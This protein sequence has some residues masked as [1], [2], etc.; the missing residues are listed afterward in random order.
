MIGA[1]RM[2]VAGAAMHRRALVPDQQI[3]DLPGM[4]IDK[5]LLRGMRRQLFDQRPGG[6][7]MH[8]DKAMRVH[9][10]D[11][12][13]RAAGDRVRDDRGPGLFGVF[14]FGRALVVA[15]QALAGRSVAAAV[16][17]DE[18]GQPLLHR[19][20]QRVIGGRI[21]ANIVPPLRRR[22]F[23]RVQHREQRQFLFIGRVGVPIGGALD[24]V[25]VDLAVLLDIGQPRDFRVFGMA[26]F[27]QR[28]LARHAET[29]PKEAISPASS[30]WSRNTSTGCSAKAC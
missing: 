1:P 7:A 8:S 19:L 3:A 26:V 6:V 14:L 15:V 17:P 20:G 11:E 9:R 4:I 27:D 2:I 30:F 21:L 5:P 12:Q 23:E 13:D 16:Q 18:T 25:P 28:M 24:P 22:H 10:V 29:P